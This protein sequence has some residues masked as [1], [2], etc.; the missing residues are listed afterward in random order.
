[1]YN[2][3]IADDDRGFVEMLGKRI[4]GEP[5]YRVVAHVYDGNDA[6]ELIDKLRPD[7]IILDIVMPGTDGIYA[8]DYARNR[9]KGYNPFI[10][11]LSGMSSN[12]IIKTL[13]RLEI[14]HFSLKPVS[15]DVVVSNLNHI[16]EGGSSAAEAP[17]RL[18]RRS[19]EPGE[20]VRELTL[21][22]GVYP[23]RISVQCLNYALVYCLENPGGVHSLTKVLYPEIAKEYNLSVPAVERN[24]RYAI[25]QMQKSKTPLFK[26]IFAYAEDKKISNGEFL[27]VVSNYLDRSRVM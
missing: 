21:Q 26:K 25:E 10:Y 12:K 20:V 19:F 3:L 9:I 4:G 1:M 23:H 13:G 6:V 27:G 15:L 14:D 11:I 24:I 18:S 2:V 16:V 7:I 17:E 22:L 5:A 8:A